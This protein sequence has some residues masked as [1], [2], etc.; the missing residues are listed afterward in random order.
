MLV[1]FRR[2]FLQDLSPLPL[3]QTSDGCPVPRLIFPSLLLL[4]YFYLLFPFFLL[5]ILCIDPFLKPHYLTWLLTCQGSWWASCICKLPA[6][7]I[8]QKPPFNDCADKNEYIKPQGSGLG[9]IF[10]L[11]LWKMLPEGLQGAQGSPPPPTHPRPQKLA[12]GG[13]LDLKWRFF[14]TLKG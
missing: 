9:K 8:K 11:I 4:S 14:A 7:A 2:C 6:N 1:P 5:D 13:F 12:V 3:I 10:L